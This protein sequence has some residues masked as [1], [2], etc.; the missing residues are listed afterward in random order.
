M[1]REDIENKEFEAS[2]GGG[3]VKIVVTGKKEV[4]KIEL[5]P[6]VVDPDDIETLEEL[7]VAAFNEAS[8]KADETMSNEL[9][10]LTG[11]MNLPG[12]F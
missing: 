5:K 10:K 12:M 11:G 8:K 2:V 6:E 3:V 4:K 9:G 7:I 1:K